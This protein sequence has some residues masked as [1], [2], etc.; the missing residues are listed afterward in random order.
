MTGSSGHERSST[1]MDP[2]LAAALAY[3][4]GALT[5]VLMLALERDSRFVRFHATQSI[6]F[7]LGVMVFVLL[8]GGLPVVGRLLSVAASVGAVVLWVVLMARAF[9][10]RWFKLPYLGEA[11]DEHLR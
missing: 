11:I 7:S 1:G 5:G 3:V 4:L 2:T 10:G 8:V 6:V 9:Q